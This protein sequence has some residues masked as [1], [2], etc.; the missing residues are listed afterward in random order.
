MINDIKNKAGVNIF[1]IYS[2][3]LNLLLNII[4]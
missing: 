4:W 3:T 1:L 2:K